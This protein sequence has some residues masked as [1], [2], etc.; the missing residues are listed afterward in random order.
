MQAPPETPNNT[1]APLVA[2]TRAEFRR[3]VEGS[4]AESPEA[5]RP[6]VKPVG[7]KA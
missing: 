4:E 5:Q 2:V 6:G 3:A 1:A 7:G